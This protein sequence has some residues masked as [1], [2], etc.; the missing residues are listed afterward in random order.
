MSGVG[1]AAYQLGLRLIS[2]VSE[3]TSGQTCRITDSDDTGLSQGNLAWLSSC[4][5]TETSCMRPAG[6]RCACLLHVVPKRSL[7][8]D[9][10]CSS[11][12]SERRTPL[13]GTR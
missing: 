11:G 12:S 13:C 8:T 4:S 9:S 5:S 7:V 1:N 10:A 3:Q 6:T 2:K